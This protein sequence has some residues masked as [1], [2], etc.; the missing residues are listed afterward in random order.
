MVT[1]FT[2]EP[3]L[4]RDIEEIVDLAEA[5]HDDMS[6]VTIERREKRRQSRKQ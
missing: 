6:E 2:G 5:L 4:Q 3:D 1:G